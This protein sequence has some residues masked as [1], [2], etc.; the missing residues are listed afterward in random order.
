MIN[1]ILSGGSGTRLWP[2]SRKLEPK[3][4]YKLISNNSLFQETV[5]RNKFSCEKQ[6][7]VLN[8]ETYFMAVDQLEEIKIKNSNFLIEPIGK[9]T[10]PAIALACMSLEVN[11][12][13]IITPSE[14]YDK[15]Y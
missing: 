11:D 13:V 3:Q 1:I 2:L 7:I 9:N 12:I 10:A 8:D 15:K 4:F 6:F 5:L 14:S